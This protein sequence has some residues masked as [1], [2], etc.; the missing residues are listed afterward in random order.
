MKEFIAFCGNTSEDHTDAQAAIE[1]V[2][3]EPQKFTAVITSFWTPEPEGGEVIREFRRINPDLPL[4]VLSSGQVNKG[5]DL[6]ENLIICPRSV[7]SHRLKEI[8]ED[9]N[10]DC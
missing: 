5:S 1:S 4:I 10:V 2:K 7:D 9:I 3:T 8:L 6:A